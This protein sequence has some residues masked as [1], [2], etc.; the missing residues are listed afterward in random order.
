MF[1]PHL[2]SQVLALQMGGTENANKTYRYLCL[3][4]SAKDLCVRNHILHQLGPLTHSHTQ[5]SSSTE[6]DNRSNQETAL[7]MHLCT[8]STLLGR[9]PRDNQWQSLEKSMHSCCVAHAPNA[10]P[11]L[12]V[13]SGSLARTC[14]ECFP[15]GYQQ[16]DEPDN[17][18]GCQQVK[19]L[20]V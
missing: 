8:I 15:S 19:R 2:F 12:K 17:R 16:A 1:N 3:D 9:S 18:S 6:R 20:K 11:L 4:E 13:A 5:S 7:M 14:M 10:N